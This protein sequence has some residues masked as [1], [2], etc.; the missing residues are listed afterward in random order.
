MLFTVNNSQSLRRFVALG[1]LLLVAL[2]SA[3][4]LQAQEGGGESSPEDTSGAIEEIEVFGVRESLR[5][6]IE[7]KRYADT[8]VDSLRA[9]DIGKLPDVS[10]ADALA[11][12]PGIT[13]E[14]DR[15]NGSTVSAR[16]LGPDLVA[17]LLNGREIVTAE[18]SRIPNFQQFPAE[19]INGAD[20]FKSAV[21][22]QVEGGL[23]ATIDLQTVR[24]LEVS[25][26]ILTIGGQVL[27]NDVAREL[28]G[29][30][31]F[32]E[33]LQLSY[34]DQYLDGAL[35]LAV[36]YAR[37]DQ[38]VGTV[39][40]SVY[41]ALTSFVDT[42]NGNALDPTGGDLIPEGVEYS[43]RTGKDIRDAATLVL[44][45][46]PTDNLTLYYDALYSF[47]RIRD[48]QVRTGIVDLVFGNDFSG[49]I[50]DSQR[51]A[52]RLNATSTNV[53]FG[54]KALSQTERFTRRD[55]FFANGLNIAY[56][57]ERWRLGLDIGYSRVLR[58]DVF[59]QIQIA[60]ANLAFVD[61]I[62]NPSLR[63]GLIQ[64]RAQTVSFDTRGLFP[65]FTTNRDLTDLDSIFITQVSVPESDASGIEDELGAIKFDFDYFA[66][67]VSTISAGFRVS[68][69]NKSSQSR[70]QLI[71]RQEFLAAGGQ[72][73]VRDEWIASDILGDYNGPLDGIASFPT[74]DFDRVLD[75]LG[76]EIN[77]GR[78]SNTDDGRNTWFIEED[79]FAFYTQWDFEA[80]LGSV[81]L[82][83]NAG[84]RHVHTRQS[85]RGFG[86]DSLNNSFD[87][88]VTTFFEVRKNRNHFL[89]AINLN[90]MLSDRQQ[91]RLALAKTISRPPLDDLRPG[92]GVF[93]TIEGVAND[94]SFAGA[95]FGGNPDL[96]PF[97]A[98]Q[99]DVTYEYYFADES[100]VTLSA[101]YKELDTFIID[102]FEPS[103]F[104]ADANG[105]IEGAEQNLIVAR[106]TNGEGGQVSGVEILY[107]Q[108]F[109]ILPR[110]WGRLGL[111]T[112]YSYT[113]SNAE[114]EQSPGGN[115]APVVQRI[116]G[117]A[118]HVGVA[119]LWFNRGRYEA[120]VSYRAR[121]SSSI[122]SNETVQI[123]DS[124]GIL[125]VQTSYTLRNGLS[126]FAQASN[127]TD[128]RFETYYQRKSAR[129]RTEDFGR[130]YYLGLKYRWES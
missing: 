75:D 27:A 82:L 93:Q 2:F 66:S 87:D 73:S 64:D 128:Q 104:D 92:L 25:G 50:L 85:I 98:D 6:A 7:V 97:E 124:E 103:A 45:W 28:N 90:L 100:A 31:D 10:I 36:G 105:T 16:G 54:A 19:L 32:G 42:Q 40:T 18:R 14:R 111:Y 113:D 43:V 119:T 127:L 101:F 69:R 74:L 121:S 58:D 44:E 91:I 15:G 79:S 110:S 116:R 122:R 83:G 1:A 11:R 9:E 129:A 38:P 76:I 41:P 29:E 99:I 84:F 89:P 107:Q 5:K 115:T 17:S 22:R 34:I 125:Q 71:E 102:S 52:T 130:F 118:R 49:V 106:P 57:T 26:R 126:V 123:G 56:A 72:A 35:G 4:T 59:A 108:P 95:G 120:S 24:P 48:E 78:G 96:E 67:D 23:A 63:T 46:L 112:T 33:R 86:L 60:P 30:D 37:L 62:N 88:A 8:V 70:S 53:D 39:R 109:D 117:L 81:L 3:A 47:T 13:V 12:L 51:R 80:E 61:E 114:I 65:A 20:V 21:A 77:P 94:G 68:K 55:E